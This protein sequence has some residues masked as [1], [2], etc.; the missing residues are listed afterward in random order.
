MKNTQKPTAYE[1]LIEL[2][3]RNLD[4]NSKVTYYHHDLMNTLGC[5]HSTIVK[6]VRQLRERNEDW[7]VISGTGVKDMLTPTPTTYRYFSATDNQK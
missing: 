6:I 2:L 5:S 3:L 4:E 1:R 7:T